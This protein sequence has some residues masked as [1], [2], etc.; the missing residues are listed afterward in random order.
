MLGK[1]E[2]HFQGKG[3]DLQNLA[4]QIEQHLNND[5]FHTQTG[6]VGDGDIVIQAQKGGFLDKVID[7]DRALTISISGTGDDFTVTFG[8]GKWLKHLGIAVIE[9]LLLSDIF[10][11]VDLAESAWTIEVEDK[12]AK[13]VEAMV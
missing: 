1:K 7:A 8:I 2:L 11:V 12:L 4:S 6:T 3:T 5:K 13:A 9:T 10:L